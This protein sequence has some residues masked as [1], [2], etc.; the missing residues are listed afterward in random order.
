MIDKMCEPKV[1]RAR[2]ETSDA[3]ERDR[4]VQFAIYHL[5]LLKLDDTCENTRQGTGHRFLRLAATM[6]GGFQLENRHS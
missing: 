4:L 6:L 1:K 2:T 5:V 3:S